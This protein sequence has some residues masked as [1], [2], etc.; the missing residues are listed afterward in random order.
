MFYISEI[1]ELKV[2][3]VLLVVKVL[4]NVDWFI[5]GINW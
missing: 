2:Y 4:F 5:I 1:R 3:V